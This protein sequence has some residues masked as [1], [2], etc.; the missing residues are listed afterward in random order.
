MQPAGVGGG[1]GLGAA[2]D[3]GEGGGQ[4]AAGEE[5][6]GAQEAV[7]A[8]R[9]AFGE[10]VHRVVR[11]EVG[12]DGV[13]AAG[14]DDAGSG[15]A[16]PGVVLDVRPVDELGLAGEVQ[17]VGAGLG[18]GGDEFRAVPDVRADGGGQYPGGGGQFAQCP[19]VAGVGPQEGQVRAGRVEG[20]EAFAQPF[21][22]SEVPARQG[23]SAVGGGRA[24]RGTRR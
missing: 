19:G 5:G 7:H 14:V 8:E 15:L 13:E 10:L 23:P 4:G 1:Q 16:G 24:R 20:G 17:V 12:R 11:A 6:V 2:A 21:Q 3:R 18:A 22:L 9:D